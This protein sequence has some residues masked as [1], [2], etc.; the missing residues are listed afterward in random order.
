MCGRRKL[1][2][3]HPQLVVGKYMDMSLVQRIARQLPKGIIVQFHNNGEPTMYPKLGEALKL[4]ENQVRCFNTNGKLILDKYDE[5][6]NNVDTM[7][8]SVIENDP[9]AE[10]QYQLVTTFLSKKG[11]RKPRLIYRLLGNVENAERWH[12]LP[13]LV[14][15]RVLH[16]PEGSFGYEKKVT[17]PE[18]G[19]CIEAFNHMAIS[20]QGEVSMCVRFDPN[21]VGVLGNVRNEQ[22]YDIW[23]GAKRQHWLKMHVEGWRSKIQLCSKCDFYG[24][25]RGD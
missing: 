18:V 19:F 1:E 22:L 8:I 15:T 16:K 5:I 6:C 21:R 2:K 9:E 11:N 17:I 14:A 25:P 13:G 10:A 3:T 12:K 4:F 23:N 20:C 7:T 24:V